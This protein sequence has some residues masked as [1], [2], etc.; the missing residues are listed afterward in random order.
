MI[1]PGYLTINHYLALV[2]P[3]SNQDEHLV[4]GDILLAYLISVN[5]DI[6][7]LLMIH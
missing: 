4:H 6:S 3:T 7:V 2:G 1:S 5:P